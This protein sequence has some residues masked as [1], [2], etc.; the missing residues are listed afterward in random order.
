MKNWEMPVMEELTI[1]ETA[2]GGADFNA[3]D[4]TWVDE[5]GEGFTSY[6]PIKS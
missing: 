5:K 3:A 6:D 2:Q 1:N 4:R